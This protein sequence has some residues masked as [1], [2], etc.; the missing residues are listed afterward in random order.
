MSFFL[1]CKLTLRVKGQ[2][3]EGR[4][5]SYLCSK[6]S[7]TV[8]EILRSTNKKRW[9]LV[10]FPI[11]LSAR[12]LNNARSSEQK[13]SK[14]DTPSSH[15]NILQK[16]GFTYTLWAVRFAWYHSLM[17]IRHLFFPRTLSETQYQRLTVT[18]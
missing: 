2:K 3:A 7:A 9:Q 6:L 17:C 11:T 10:Y 15:A 13:R 8:I 1:Q 12:T 18:G 14:F 5:R 4:T 16:H